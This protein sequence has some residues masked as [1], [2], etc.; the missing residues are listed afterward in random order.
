MFWKKPSKA[1]H[2]ELDLTDQ[3]DAYRVATDPQLNPP[4]SIVLPEGCL[5]VQ[6]I[7]AGGLSF[8]HTDQQSGMRFITTLQLPGIRCKAFE[9]TLEIMRITQNNIVHCRFIELPEKQQD[10]IHYFVLCQQKHLLDTHPNEA[11]ED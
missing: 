3:R 2:I 5:E 8:M 6:E 7:S 1:V 10:K 4:P 9:V 11:I